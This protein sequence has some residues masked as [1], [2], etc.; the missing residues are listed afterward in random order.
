VMAERLARQAAPCRRAREG[1]HP[2]PRIEVAHSG[3]ASSRSPRGKSAP[4]HGCCNRSSPGRP[5]ALAGP[6]W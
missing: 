4:R 1:E 5:A 3:A 6:R 2:Q